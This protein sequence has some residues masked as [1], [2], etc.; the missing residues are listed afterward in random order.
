MIN[1]SIFKVFILPNFSKDLLNPSE[2]SPS[3][4]VE[5]FQELGRILRIIL[6]LRGS[7]L[8]NILLFL[9]PK[10]KEL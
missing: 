6:T 1:G 9:T 8:L 7:R 3:I 4:Y 10:Q 5:V 2:E